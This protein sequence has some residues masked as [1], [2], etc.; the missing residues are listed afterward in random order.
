MVTIPILSPAGEAAGT[1]ELSSDVFGVETHHAL[2]HQAIVALQA[3]ARQ[4]TADTKTRGEVQHTTRKLYRQ[5][6]TG[7]A[8][9]GM[10]SA[11]HWKGG[12]IVFGPHPRS[13]GQS[14]NKKMRRQ[15]LLCAISSRVA[16]NGIVVVE[17]FGLSELKTRAAVKLLQT[18]GLA[19]VK[20]LLVVLDQYSEDA[21]RPFRNLP[22]VELTTAAELCTYDVLYAD[23]ILF[24][25]ASIE[26]FAELKSQPVGPR[27]LAID[28]V[29]GG[30]A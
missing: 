6:G 24:T 14:L 1:L 12:G 30:A 2:L 25:R 4:G 8:R 27:R 3:N 22:Q 21:A 5:K 19:D 11:P 28:A 20:K 23:R 15:A 17:D 16:D 10:R 7:R 18:I 9:Q 26:R 13:Y 29:Q